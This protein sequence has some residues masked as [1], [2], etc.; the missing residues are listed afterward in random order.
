MPGENIQDWSTTAASNAT[1]DA[2]I[3]WAE[4]QARASVNDSARSMMAAVAK[5]RNLLNGSIST[6]GSVNAQTFTSGV[7]YTGAPPTG[8]LVRLKIGVALTNT[9]TTTLNMDSIGAVTILDEAGA[10]LV[11]GALRA[12]AYATFIY[13]GT[14]WILLNLAQGALAVTGNATIG[15]TLA[16]TGATTLSSTLSAAGAAVFNSTVA[17]NGNTTLGDASTDTV[18]INAKSITQ[19]NMPAFSASNSVADTNAT[20]DGTAFV[21]D[22]DTEAFDRSGD[23]AADTFTASVT[24][25]YF[26]VITVDLSSLGAGHVDCT[27]ELFVNGV[28]PFRVARLNPIAIAFSGALCISLPYVLSLTATNTVVGRVTVAGSTKT[29]SLGVNTALS[30]FLIG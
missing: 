24:G 20:G 21:I 30:G 10:A 14:N 11:A 27:I 2:S 19:P 23:F 25:V 29:V 13:N 6:G 3:G 16:V 7:S 18:I 8:L 12:G 17:V 28:T 5:W 4:G 26:F 1:A 15:G 22:V 9:A